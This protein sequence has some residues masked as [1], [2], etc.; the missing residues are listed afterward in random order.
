MPSVATTLAVTSRKEDQ[1]E[2]VGSW[3]FPGPCEYT[4]NNVTRD[5]YWHLSPVT[6]A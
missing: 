2:Q 3:A 6:K 4:T 5:I 1:L